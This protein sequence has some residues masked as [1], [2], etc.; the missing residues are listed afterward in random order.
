MTDLRSRFG[1]IRARMKQAG[2]A[3][4]PYAARWFRKAGNCS[5][6][7]T[8]PKSKAAITAKLPGQ[9]ALNRRCAFYF[10]RDRK[11]YPSVRPVGRAV[12]SEATAREMDS[13]WALA[14]VAARA[15]ASDLG[16]GLA[17]QIVSQKRPSAQQGIFK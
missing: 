14:L 6:I 7:C 15:Q 13:A 17:Y 4:A 8:T 10:R 1:S 2:S 12:D 5:T 11:V 9:R 16:S 3:L